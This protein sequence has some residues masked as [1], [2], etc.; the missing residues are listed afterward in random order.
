MSAAGVYG[1]RLLGLPDDEGVRRA[2]LEVPLGWPAV[3]L[4]LVNGEAADPRL[5]ERGPARVA[6]PLPGGGSAVMCRDTAAATIT[7]PGGLAND[8]LVHPGLA[9]VASV[10]SGWLGRRVF[11]A[12]AFVV[13]GRAWGILGG[14]ESGKSSTL[15]YLSRAGHSVLAD[16]MLVLDGLR[17]FGGPRSIDLRPSTADALRVNGDAT[18]VRA[19]SR[20][21]IAAAAIGT[22][23]PLHGWFVL[24]WGDRR[25][26]RRLPPSERLAV[27]A[28]HCH[29]IQPV[30]ALGMLDLIALP[31]FELSRPQDLTSLPATAESLVRIARSE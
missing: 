8:S 5:P 2:M 21:R 9:Y 31:A 26:E 10:F 12:G 25:T 23:C 30:E 1:L 16:D 27:L 13:D 7:R 22:D 14:H 6:L 29:L 4:E 28:N 3:H 11:H 18:A 24:T 20:Q 19:G 17:A 15:G